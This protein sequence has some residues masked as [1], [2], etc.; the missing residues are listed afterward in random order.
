MI[1]KRYIERISPVLVIDYTTSPDDVFERL[2]SYDC[3]VSDYIMPKMN[4]IELAQKVRERAR[5]RSPTGFVAITRDI[6]E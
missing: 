6:T 3:I 2:D 1:S 4:G 5:A